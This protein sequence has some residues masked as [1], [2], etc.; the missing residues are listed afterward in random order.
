[1]SNLKI[2]F[3][4]AINGTADNFTCLLFRLMLKADITNLHKLGSVYPEEMQMV[5]EYKFG[6][7]APKI[8]IVPT[9]GINLRI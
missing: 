3:D 6:I 9:R 5:R 1:M 4:N 7:N 8:E 2:D